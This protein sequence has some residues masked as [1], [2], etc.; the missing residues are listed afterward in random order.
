MA[1]KMTESWKKSICNVI[2]DEQSESNNISKMD[3]ESLVIN[4]LTYIRKCIPFPVT[5]YESNEI[6]NMIS[7][8]IKGPYDTIKKRLAN[9]EGVA[10]YLSSRASKLDFD[11][12]YLDWNILHL[13][14]GNINADSFSAERTEKTLHL[15]VIRDE[16]YLIKIG[17]HGSD[18]Y[19]D[20][21]ELTIVYN[22]WPKLLNVLNFIPD[23]DINSEDRIK[24]RNGGV[25]AFTT[26]P[27]NT[28]KLITAFPF[29]SL[30][31]STNKTSNYD[32]LLLNKRI[33]EIINGIV[34]QAKDISKKSDYFSEGQFYYSPKETCFNFS[35]IDS[36]E[37]LCSL[38][39]FNSNDFWEKIFA[40]GKKL[41][42]KVFC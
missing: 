6:K 3:D 27:D 35:S 9:G 10:P 22:N 8:E 24:V 14:L 17:K 5:V 30:G 15:M 25:N 32:S 37:N 4:Y 29:Q 36:Q 18:A 13:H 23:Q 16:A 41:T 31:Y 38:F 33:P 28:G 42:I 21:D 39:E 40:N 12:L 20:L 2:K 1:D 26:F 19:T 34:K 7:D 11:G